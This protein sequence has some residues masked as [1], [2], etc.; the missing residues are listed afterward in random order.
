MADKGTRSN[1][2]KRNEEGDFPDVMVFGDQE[3]KQGMPIRYGENPHQPAAL[4]VIETE[5]NTLASAE[6]VYPGVKGLSLINFTDLNASL[7]LIHDL[8]ELH[9]SDVSIAIPIKHSTPS[10]VGIS[11]KGEPVE[12][13]ENALAGDPQ[14]IFGCC[15]GVSDEV[16][17]DLAKKVK[18]IFLEVI[19]APSFTPEAVVFLNQHRKS[20]RLLAFGSLDNYVKGEFEYL[21]ISGGVLVQRT[22]YSRIFGPD[23]LEV[24]TKR[25]PTEDEYRALVTMWRVASR[26]KS[27]AVVIGS[28][29]RTFGIG[30]G[31]M[32]RIASA[33]IAVY[34]ARNVYMGG[35]VWDGGGVAAS[36]A[37]FPFPDAAQELGRARVKAVIYPLGSQNDSQVIET[38]DSY[39]MAAVCTRPEPGTKEI[40]RC[41][42][43]HKG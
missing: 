3:A 5:G 22:F 29:D 20:T 9:G 6:L 26:V 41:F 18:D 35:Q 39:N 40:E 30:T 27:N 23:Q 10:G 24:V 31:Q 12:A 16:D 13:F 2:V 19:A 15:L 34:N 1:Y 14:S 4:F 33:R 7:T 8:Y 17:I 43:G 21:P 32:S 42:S 36:D 11:Y 37:F 38:W 28:D 25:E